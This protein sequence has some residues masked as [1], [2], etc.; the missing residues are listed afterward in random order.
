MKH[1]VVYGHPNPKSFSHAILNTF[2][3]RL[4][5]KKHEVR[6]RDLYDL[7]FDPCL[8][9][10]ELALLEK[11]QV[12]KDIQSEQEHVRWADIVTFIYPLWWTGLPAILKG[13][14]DR[15]FSQG[16]AYIDSE[17]GPKGL[18]PGKKIFMMTPM[19]APE[20]VY[21]DMGIFKS[22]NQVIDESLT[23][24]CGM[25]AVGHKYF[26]QVSAVSQEARAE[27]LEEVKRLA[28]SLA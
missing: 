8:K 20:K 25:T 7:H 1:L 9:G 24:F 19:G 18:L 28:D 6:V 3:E 22:M 13:Y 26:G 14:L 4:R 16:F 12:P 27:M 17:K 15:V 10:S 21:A 2:V 23:G 11:G 5:E